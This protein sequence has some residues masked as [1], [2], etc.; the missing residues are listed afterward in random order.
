MELEHEQF[1]AIQIFGFFLF[2]YFLNKDAIYN[3]AITLSFLLTDFNKAWGILFSFGAQIIGGIVAII[4]IRLSYPK[5]H[6][7]DMEQY[8]YFHLIIIESIC[9]FFLTFYYHSCFVD[10][11]Q[12]QQGPYVIV[13]MAAIYGGFKMCFPKFSAGYILLIFHHFAETKFFLFSLLG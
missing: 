8:N 4:F 3:P 9:S 12:K 7:I 10:F 6:E 11:K 13:G 2:A 1:V 5:I